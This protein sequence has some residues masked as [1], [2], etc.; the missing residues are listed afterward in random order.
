MLL[1]HVMQKYLVQLGYLLERA[2]DKLSRQVY[3]YI[4]RLW[5]NKKW[6]ITLP[7]P[8]PGCG[9]INQPGQLDPNLSDRDNRTER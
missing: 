3:L 5:C 2:G 7:D 8:N 6:L 1:H 9:K 4:P